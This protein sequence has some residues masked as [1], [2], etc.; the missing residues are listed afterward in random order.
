MTRGKRMDTHRITSQCADRWLVTGTWCDDSVVFLSDRV[1]H[2]TKGCNA[3]IALQL[4]FPAD[5]CHILHVR[6][7]CSVQL[8]LCK[9]VV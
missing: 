6:L 1:P 9:Q 8:V 4:H 5:L 2:R 3:I 7:E